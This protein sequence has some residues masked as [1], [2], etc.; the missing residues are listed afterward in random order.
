MNDATLLTSR[1]SAIG[2]GTLALGLPVLG[3]ALAAPAQAQTKGKGLDLTNKTDFLTAV[4]K[5]RGALDDR[6]CMGYVKGLYYGVVDAKITPLYGVLG[7]TFSRYKKNADGNYEGKTFEVAY[8]T[9]WATG[10]LL[11]TFKNPYTGETVEVPQTRMGP[12]DILITPEGLKIAGE[13]AMRAMSISHRFLPARIVND[14]VWIV[15]ET[16]V[17]TPPDFKGPKFA[18]NEVT[19]LQTTLT[20]LND[21]KLMQTA[22]HVHFNGVVSWR[23]W[24]KMGDRPGHLL[25]NAAGRR[26]NKMTDYPAEYQEWTKKYHADVWAD[27]GKILD[28][29]KAG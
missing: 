15:D 2:F 14:D 3:S 9:D 10:D 17:S 1:R 25:G 28:S 8:F 19:T 20:E 4:Q 7:G 27:P 6:I 23:P 18:Y 16:S 12:S 11:K 24:L 29:K 21:P 5:M 13:S 26:L 22:T